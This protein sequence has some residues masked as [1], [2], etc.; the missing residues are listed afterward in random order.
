MSPNGLLSSTLLYE[1]RDKSKLFASPWLVCSDRA[2]DI[3]GA[4]C[5]LC[6][7]NPAA[8]IK[9]DRPS[10]MGLVLGSHPISTGHSDPPTRLYT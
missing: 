8:K 4:C 2:R 10:P 7:E 5:N 9:L 3:A 6:P 1:N